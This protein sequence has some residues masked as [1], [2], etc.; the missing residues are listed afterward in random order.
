[1]TTPTFSQLKPQL[2]QCALMAIDELGFKQTTPVQAATIPLFLSHKVSKPVVF[3]EPFI[4][5]TF[6]GCLRTGHNRIRKD[7]CFWYTDI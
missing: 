7:C 2:S 1:M 3:L 6:A 5:I 4:H